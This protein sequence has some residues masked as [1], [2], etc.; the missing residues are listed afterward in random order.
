MVQLYVSALDASVTAPIRHLEGFARIHLKP[1][2][3]TRVRFTLTPE[4]LASYTDDGTPIVE[5]GR[6]RISVG[7]GQP[8]NASSPCVQA[9]LTVRA[10][11]SV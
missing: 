8:G 9:V 10:D 2:R 4:Q 7:G 11:S 3:R 6:Y 5:A 1:G